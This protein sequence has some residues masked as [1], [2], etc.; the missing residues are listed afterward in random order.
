MNGFIRY[1]HKISMWNFIWYR[2]ANREGVYITNI[3]ETKW[4]SAKNRLNAANLK[5][6]ED[7]R[8]RMEA[9]T[10]DHLLKVEPEVTFAILSIRITK[11]LIRIMFKIT[12]REIIKKIQPVLELQ[13]SHGFR[14]LEEEAYY[15]GLAI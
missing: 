4:D 3:F 11:M 15:C 10:L 13:K 5:K 12:K 14:Q 6:M 2:I 8:S 1:A 9:H 7:F